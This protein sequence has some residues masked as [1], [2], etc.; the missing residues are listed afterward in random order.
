MKKLI[1]LLLLSPLAYAEEE[2]FVCDDM[3]NLEEKIPTSLLVNTKDKY[4]IFDND[5]YEFWHYTETSIS[6]IHKN[7]AS[8]VGEVI[9]KV[10]IDKISGWVE[11]SSETKA[12]GFVSGAHK[13]SKNNRLID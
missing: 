3:K 2:T 7:N 11:S 5:R 12:F 6:A 9:K 10:E 13:C 4:L 1:A 8:L